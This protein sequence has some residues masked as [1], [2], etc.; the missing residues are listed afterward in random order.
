M[1]RS[2]SRFFLVSNRVR[3]TLAPAFCR[4]LLVDKAVLILTLVFGFLS[5]AVLLCAYF[6]IGDAPSGRL[7]T[8]LFSWISVAFVCAIGA[9]WVACRIVYGGVLVGRLIYSE[10][11]ERS[12]SDL[13]PK[14]PQ[15]G[16]ARAA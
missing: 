13:N 2:N 9:P 4:V 10:F 11:V 12:P 1:R 8:A 5:A 16:L 15:T 3:E 7:A 6:A 14:L